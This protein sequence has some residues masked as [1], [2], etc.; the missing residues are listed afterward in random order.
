VIGYAGRHKAHEARRRL[1]SSTVNGE[2]GEMFP[3]QR[4]THAGRVQNLGAA[5]PP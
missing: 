3:R 1:F 4:A 2:R 5:F